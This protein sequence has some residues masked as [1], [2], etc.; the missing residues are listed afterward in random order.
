MNNTANKKYEIRVMSLMVFILYFLIVIGSLNATENGLVIVGTSS[1]FLCLLISSFGL[2]TYFFINKRLT[3][4][5]IVILSQIFLILLICVTSVLN[6]TYE[7]ADLINSTQIILCLNLLLYLSCVGI[8][9]KRVMNINIVVI[10]FILFHL[11]VWIGSGL[12]NLFASIY[13]NS[14]LIGPYMFYTSFFLIVG[15]K[16]SRYK[17][18]YAL[19]V[20]FSLLLIFA[21]DTRSIFL[22]VF[23]V[24]VMFLLW[25]LITKTKIIAFLFFIIITVFILMFIF[26]YPL[27]P[28][29]QFFM[30]LEQW[31]VTHTGKSLMSG[32]NDL[33]VPLVE[34]INLKPLVGYSPG[35][36]ASEIIGTNQSPH[37]LYLNILMQTGYLSLLGFFIIFATIWMTLVKVKDNFIVRLT[38]CYFIAIL[39]HQSFEITL[40]QNQLSIG[41]LQW[42]IL[43]LGLSIAIE[44]LH[45]DGIKNN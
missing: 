2:L 1:L 4:S 6:N 15:L 32:R 14:N 28:T 43:G 30:P 37:N 39:V 23:V 45:N 42:F 21:S 34:M 35:T 5:Q 36:L 24:L 44:E 25:P 27:L 26:V 10:A 16:Y 7:M 3:S 12:P 19:M 17:I 18:F 9:I 22:S 8:D 11:F 41:L 29:F 20:F 31:M 38:A 40:L 33:W 13:N